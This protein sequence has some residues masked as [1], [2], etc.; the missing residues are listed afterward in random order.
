MKELKI[1]DAGPAD[2]AAIEKVFRSHGAG[3]WRF[4]RRFYQSY[5]AAPE[6][7]TNHVVLVGCVGERI[8][9]VIGYIQDRVETDDVFW[10]G[11]F[12]V[13]KDE[14]GKHYGEQLLGRVVRE[15]KERGARKLYTDTSSWGFYSRAHHRY[16]E[17]GFKLEAQL[18]D[19]YGEGEHQVIYGMDL[20]CTG[21]GPS[22]A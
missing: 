19:Y 10:L 18:A 2:L 11:W 15:L 8:V 7:H 22:H 3:D 13:H 6:Q 17:F 21:I 4:A 14:A 9:G 16:Q 12:Y 1:R 5:F 20:A